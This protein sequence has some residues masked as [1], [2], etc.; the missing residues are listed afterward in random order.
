MELPT[1]TNIW[2]I[3][4]RLYKLYDFR[5]PMPLPVGQVAAFLAI[6][7]PYMVI[8]TM[9]GM[10]FSHT[11]VWLYVLPP[12]VLAWLVTRPVLEGKRLP[13]L[14][15]SQL[16]YLSEPRTWCRM[17]ALAEK[18]QIFV[19]AKVWRRSGI[20][21][22]AVQATSA[23][24][25]DRYVPADARP[26]SQPSVAEA[27]AVHAEAQPADAIRPVWPTRPAIASR[28]SVP[29][30]QPIADTSAVPTQV[31]VPASSARAMS[32]RATSA[33]AAQVARAQA[34][35]AQA[36][37]VQAAEA[38]AAPVPAPPAQAAAAQM[39]APQAPAPQAP[40]PQ[41]PPAQAP[42]AKV[43]SDQ[44]PTGQ[45]APAA[46]QPRPLGRPV[47]TVRSDGSPSRPLPVVERA[48][49]NSPSDRAGWHER[50]VVVPGGHRP[51]KPDQLQRDQAR[52]RFP[53][54]GP[55]RIVVLG[56]TAGAGQTTTTLLTGQLLATLRGEAVAVLDIGAGPG[57]LTELARQVPRL[58]PSHRDVGG[59]GS[60]GERGL[61]VVTADAP[62]DQPADAGKLIDAVVA[63]YRI[64]IADPAAAH[65]PR[66]AH[67][68]DQ[69][70]LVAPAS[71]DAAGSLAMTMEWLEVHGH[72]Q[73]ARD[74][75]AVLNGV[76]AATAAYVGKA[77]S[78]AAGRCRAVV[79]V[80]WDDRLTEGGAL[81]PATVHA[82]TALA[83]VLIAGL[84]DPAR[85][86]GAP[87]PSGRR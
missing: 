61:Q 71:A 13:E 48:L 52:A 26:A 12:G 42:P 18:D 80:P 39:P 46:G 38:Q 35:Q 51:G 11:W 73:L 36:A 9:A 27:H 85:A 29:A 3:E 34:A 43:P 56:C 25:G 1:Y 63:R 86:L 37:P 41:A 77:A 2:K 75:V 7:I 23:A 33:P 28:R 64:T 22:P 69:L 54:A 82:Y 19:T 59:A 45:G 67:V 40:A 4:K 15:V 30:S 84:A 47:V 72:A 58:L 53:L 21:A 50:V 57:S 6:A 62:A 24:T 70:V 83:G 14:V 65:V 32:A 8:L 55:V 17:A 81:G 20:A 87:A 79:Q 66:A 16:R 68:A 76:S 49:R 44:R 78:V 74:A 60:A 31:Q 10:P 5:L